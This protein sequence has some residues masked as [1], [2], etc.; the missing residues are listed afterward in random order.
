MITYPYVVVID[1]KRTQVY[2]L[3]FTINKN[4]REM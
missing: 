3:M 2:D 4:M 1:I